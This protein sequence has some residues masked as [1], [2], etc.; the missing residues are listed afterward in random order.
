TVDEPT[1][2]PSGTSVPGA[3]P[4]TTRVPPTAIP[5]APCT[6]SPGVSPVSP[7]EVAR[8][9]TS[10]PQIS[11]TFDAGADAGPAPRLLSSLAAHHVHTT[12]FIC[13]ECAEKKPDVI[14]EVRDAGHE[15]ASHAVHHRDLTALRDTDV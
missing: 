1:T 10:R 14:R 11:L 15:I 9:N 13:G 2:G 8:G 4:T 7:V 5:S 12:W 3:T 6:P